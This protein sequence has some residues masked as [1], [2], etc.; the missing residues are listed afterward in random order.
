MKEN[1]LT[2]WELKLGCV[3][4]TKAIRCNW[5]KV[6]DVLFS[7]CCR[8]RWDLRVLQNQVSKGRDLSKSVSFFLKAV[9][10]KCFF[11][12]FF[13]MSSYKI[14]KIQFHTSLQ[15]EYVCQYMN[16]K[17]LN[18]PEL[19]GTDC[20]LFGYNYVQQ[21]RKKNLHK[22]GKHRRAQSV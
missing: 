22:Q 2:E 14:V 15:L 12:F 20:F 3:V 8:N 18:S 9:L 4:D 7:C 21:K 17:I 19:F 5:F 6:E 13:K 16:I 11:F 10:R 1:S